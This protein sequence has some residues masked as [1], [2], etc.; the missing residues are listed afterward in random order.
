MFGATPPNAPTVISPAISATG[1][2]TPPISIGMPIQVG[3]GAA[4]LST[5]TPQNPLGLL[6]S[7]ADFNNSRPAQ[8]Y[9]WNL[10]IQYQAAQNLVLEAAYSAMR[11]NYLTSR[12]NLNQIPWSE[13]IR[14]FT[15]QADRLFPNVGNEVVMDSSTGNSFYNA[16]NLR[17]ENG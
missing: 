16:L 8:L 1:T 17:A 11:G 5:F 6:I 3:P 14:G 10:G 15:A 7:T 4:D 13:A 12:V 9:Q 2:V